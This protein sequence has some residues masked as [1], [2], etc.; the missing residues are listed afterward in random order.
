MALLNAYWITPFGENTVAFKRRSYDGTP[1]Y[2]SQDTISVNRPAD[3][4][5]IA[6]SP[7]GNPTTAPDKYVR[8]TSISRQIALTGPNGAIHKVVASLTV[9]VTGVGV[10]LPAH[11]AEAVS[12][13]TAFP[14]QMAG[15]SSS[16]NP[17]LGAEVK[18]TFLDAI[19]N[20]ES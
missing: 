19:L 1:E 5:Q 18:T 3:S 12:S 14:E 11:I 15:S 7:R 4:I 9:T 10:V 6:V 16:S 13:V 8:R 17:L 2:V 20:Q